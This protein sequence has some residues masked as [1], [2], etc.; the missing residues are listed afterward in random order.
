MH[1]MIVSVHTIYHICNTCTWYLL[2]MMNSTVDIIV[3]IVSFT[4]NIIRILLYQ[5]W[6]RI[7]FLV[8]LIGIRT[9]ASWLVPPF[10]HHNPD[11]CLG[12]PSH[13]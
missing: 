3:G 9:G 5:D 4:A 1:A 10:G 8:G 6:L 2:D 13:T 12:P 7:R 11:A